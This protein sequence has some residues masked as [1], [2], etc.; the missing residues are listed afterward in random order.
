MDIE[1]NPVDN[2]DLPSPIPSSTH[3][4]STEEAPL[5]ENTDDIAIIG[6]RQKTRK[7][8]TVLAKHSAKEESPLLEKGKTN[9]EPPN[10]EQLGVE[11][12]HAGYLSRLATSWDM[13]VGNMP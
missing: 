13:D 3:V 11:Q 12:V 1:A 8:S 2:R 4:N 10:Y 9:L 7:T 6:V 5:A